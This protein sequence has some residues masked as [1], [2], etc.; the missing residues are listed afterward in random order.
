[1]NKI[2]TELDTKVYFNNSCSICRFE[3]N[4]YKKLSNE[5]NWIDVTQNSEAEKETSKKA[6]QLIRRLHARHN[7]ELL[8]GID[9][10]LLVWSKLPRYNWLYRF[11]KLPLIYNLSHILYELLAFFLYLKNR[12]Q[13]KDER[14]KN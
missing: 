3:I 4:H 7:G 8:E 1:V 6:N 11:V 12:N 2:N 10:F 9:A 13:I 14:S 5:I